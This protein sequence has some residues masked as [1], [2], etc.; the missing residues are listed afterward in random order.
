MPSITCG[1]CRKTHSSV[2]QVRNC[3]VPE[4]EPKEL[5]D[6]FYKM[7][8]DIYKVIHNQSGDKQYAKKLVLE[9]NDDLHSDKEYLGKFEYAPGAIKKIKPHMALTEEDAAAFGK[10]YSICAICSTQL[11]NEE[12]IER[13]IG[14]ICAGKLG[15]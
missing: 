15:W 13:G 11:S 9:E 2:A 6:G 8:G 5:L 7:D 1:Y 3:Y 12:S 10:L 4:P 14:P